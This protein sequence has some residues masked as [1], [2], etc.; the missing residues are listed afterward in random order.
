MKDQSKDST[1]SAT[2]EGNK[3]DHRKAE[4]EGMGLQNTLKNCVITG[5]EGWTEMA[6]ERRQAGSLVSRERKQRENVNDKQMTW[7]DRRHDG[8]SRRQTRKGGRRSWSCG[9][10]GKDWQAFNQSGSRADGSSARKEHGWEQQMWG[11]KGTHQ[12]R[13]RHQW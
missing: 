10:L 4:S 12:A 6:Q 3:T 11:R 5:D 1:H 2:G 13:G 8:T 9:L 7:K